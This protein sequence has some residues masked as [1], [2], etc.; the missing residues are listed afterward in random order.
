MDY[1]HVNLVSAVVAACV[2]L[3]HTR[4]T[5]LH[6]AVANSCPLDAVCRHLNFYLTAGQACQHYY[7]KRSL[8]LGCGDDECVGI[9]NDFIER[10]IVLRN[11]EQRVNILRSCR[12]VVAVI[13]KIGVQ[14]CKGFIDYALAVG[15]YRPR[16]VI[17]SHS[18]IVGQSSLRVVFNCYLVSIII[19][20]RLFGDFADITRLSVLRVSEH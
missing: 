1:A 7:V 16:A 5:C 2:L 10:D 14:R 12:V 19:Y 3:P 6:D 8:V 17:I 4:S 18:L 20:L 9:V 15:A 11:G 13:T